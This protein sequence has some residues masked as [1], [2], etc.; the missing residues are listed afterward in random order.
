[1]IRRAAA[2]VRAALR[3]RLLRRRLDQAMDALLRPGEPVGRPDARVLDALRSGF[4]NEGWS[5][6]PA[7]LE[8]LAD[9]ALATRGDVL[10]CGPGVSTLLLGALC[11]ARGR[12]VTSLEHLPEWR[13][14]VEDE[15]RRYALPRTRVVLAPLGP[16]DGFDWYALPRLAPA[17]LGLVACDGPPGSTRGGRFGALPALRPALAPG[18]I[19]VVDDMHRAPE[20]ETV[21]RWLDEFPL[22]EEHR[23]ARCVRL[24]YAP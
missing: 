9:A 23:D 15:V 17:S 19:L 21:R 13:D 2:A 16:G 1:M 10:E 3:G 4:G 18:C 24:R 7:Y 6:E 11:G 12:E 5:G 20:Q 22:I 14:R 8:A